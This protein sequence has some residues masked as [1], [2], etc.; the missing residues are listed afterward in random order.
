MSHIPFLP[1]V[2]ANGFVSFG[3]K[4]NSSQLEP[5]PDQPE[6]H[7][8]GHNY[9][10]APFWANVSINDEVGKV[11]Y[12][13]HTAERGD[14]LLPAVS[15]YLNDYEGE[16]EFFGVWLLVVEWRDMA[17][18]NDLPNSVSALIFIDSLHLQTQLH[19]FPTR[20]PTPSSW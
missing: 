17:P 7:L 8:G 10:L 20:R 15:T 5:H 18:I 14:K 16:G 6:P 19:L 1:Q 2:S 13:V 11:F 4:P 12:E 9:L 3:H